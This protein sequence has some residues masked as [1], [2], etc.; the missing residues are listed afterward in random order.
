LQYSGIVSNILVEIVQRNIPILA[1]LVGG[2][3]HEHGIIPGDGDVQISHVILSV[4]PHGKANLLNGSALCLHDKHI[5]LLL[6]DT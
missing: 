1:L 4:L 6:V 2:E 5:V 3:S